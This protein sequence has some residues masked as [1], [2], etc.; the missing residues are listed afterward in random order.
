MST[1][2][3]RVV[4]V[5]REYGSGGAAIASALSQQLGFRLVDRALIDDV[6]QERAAYV[7]LHFGRDW[8]DRRLYDLMLNAGLGEAAAVAAI[9][10]ALETGAA[11]RD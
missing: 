4:T 8:L 1:G 7:W 9:R 6:D 2:S 3:F 5:S 11:R 10:A